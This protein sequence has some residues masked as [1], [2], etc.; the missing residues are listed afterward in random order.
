MPSGCD[1]AMGVG[2]GGSASD[3][4]MSSLADIQARDLMD[5]YGERMGKRKLDA[6]VIAAVEDDGTDGMRG[7]VTVEV[8]LMERGRDLLSSEESEFA[9][10]RAVSSLGPKQRKE[11]KDASVMDIANGLLSP[12]YV[13][14][15]SL[16]NLCVSHSVRRRGVAVRLC[17]EAERVAREIFGFDEIYLR[18]EKSNIAAL[19][20]YEKR[21]GYLR[22]FDVTGATALRVDVNAG[23]FV[24]VNT[25]IAV[26]RKKI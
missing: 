11:Y 2:D 8:R 18:V 16:S 6:A 24:E 5:K 25:D 23:S 19:R 4:C 10:T 7:L 26:L 14:V 21:L 17:L 15:C 9:L 13:A 22:A 3:A 12:D 20:L 1:P